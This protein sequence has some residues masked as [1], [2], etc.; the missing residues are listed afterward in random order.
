VTNGD[1]K[2]PYL[3]QGP[4]IDLY[5]LGPEGGSPPDPTFPWSEPYDGSG[6]NQ[7]SDAFAPQQLVCLYAKV[8]YNG[9]PV[10]NKL[11]TFEVHDASGAKITILT[12]Y[13]NW[14]DTHVPGSGIAK[15]C[16]RLPMTNTFQNGSAPTILGWWWAIATVDLDAVIVNDT[17]YF[18]VGYLF[19]VLN[20]VPIGA[21]YHLPTGT[22]SFTVTVQTI[23]EQPRD[24]LISVDEYDVQSYPIGEQVYWL[25]G[26]NATRGTCPFTGND[27]TTIPGIFIN[28]VSAP[29][30]S[31]ARAGTATVIAY[32]LTDYPRYG[33]ISWGPSASNT[34]GLIY[35]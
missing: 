25:L 34:F 7:H 9:Y 11:V 1:Y 22:M 23:S 18:Q 30:P 3:P 15:V 12:A 33:G 4:N 20:V 26:V 28:I 24:A 16:F 32:P 8:T 19:T 31:W 14:S 13:T 6:A 21:P 27:T 17:M 29:Y 10:G 5:T 2:P 35:P